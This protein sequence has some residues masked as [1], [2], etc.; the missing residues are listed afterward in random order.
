M[1][2]KGFLRI[3]LFVSYLLASSIIAS[4]NLQESP[5]VI[6]I[7]WDLEENALDGG[8]CLWVGDMVDN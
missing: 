3:I 1:E 5:A 2:P 6:V 8:C 7:H 4:Y